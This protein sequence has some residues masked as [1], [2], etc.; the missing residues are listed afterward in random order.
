MIKK[1]LAVL[2]FVGASSAFAQQNNSSPYSFYGLGDTKFKGTAENRSMGSIGVL[3]DS[4][5]LNLQNPATYGRLKFANLAVGA[6]STK[7]K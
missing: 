3:T 5:H 2:C 1:L 4:I 7:T 6:T